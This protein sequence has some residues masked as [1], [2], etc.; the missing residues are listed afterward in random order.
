VRCLASTEAEIVQ[1]NTAED[2][3]LNIHIHPFARIHQ[4]R[5]LSIA[6]NQ[7]LFDCSIVASAS[8]SRTW[9]SKKTA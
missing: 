3:N 2:V 6:P 4:L 5:S 9:R 7:Q 1:P 8:S